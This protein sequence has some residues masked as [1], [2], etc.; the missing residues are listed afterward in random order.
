MVLILSCIFMYICLYT[1]ACHAIQKQSL[2]GA[3]GVF[4]LQIAPFI[5]QIAVGSG[6]GDDHG[7]HS[8]RAR[9]LTP[10]RRPIPK[11]LPSPKMVPCHR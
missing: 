1:F 4:L 2:I 7:D 11:A 9:R 3:I 5:M 10:G 6:W 8:S